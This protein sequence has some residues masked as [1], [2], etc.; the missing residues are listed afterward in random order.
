MNSRP[1]P[2][3]LVAF[4]RTFVGREEELGHLRTAFDQAALGQGAVI[5]VAGEAGIGKTALCDRLARSVLEAGGY[6]LQGSCYEEAARS[7]PYLPF[8][9]AIR[10][11]ILGTEPDSTASEFGPNA[12]HIGRIAPDLQA[13]ATTES[14]AAALTVEE[15]HWRLLEGL[16]GFF[17]ELSNAQPLLLLLEDLH[18]ADGGSVALLRHLGRS[19]SASR[20][21]VVATYRDKEVD[22]THP[23]SGVLA[24]LRRCPSFSRIR[25]VGLDA[26][27]VERMLGQIAP[28]RVARGLCEQVRVQTD[29]NPLFVEEVIRHLFEVGLARAQ[30]TGTPA[31]DPLLASLPDGLRDVIGRRLSRLSTECHRVLAVAAVIG[32][33][34]RTDVLGDVA[35]SPGESMFG[36]IEEAAA[37]GVIEEHRQGGMPGYRF[38][39]ELVRQALY[40]ETFTPRR[41]Q[42]HQEV[43]RAVEA[44]FAGRLDDHAAE[45]A[46]HFSHA[47]DPA[48]LSRAVEYAERAATRARAVFD[49][50][51]AARLLGRAL[52]VQRALDPADRARRCDLLL[53]RGAAL[54]AANEP[55]SADADLEEAFHLAREIGDSR[56]AGHAAGLGAVTRALV[57]SAVMLIE[58]RQQL[59]VRRLEQYAPPGTPARV[60][61]DTYL[62]SMPGTS[63]ERA[64]ELRVHALETA[65]ETGDQDCIRWAAAIRLGFES[66]PMP[67]IREMIRLVDATEGGHLSNLAMALAYGGARLLREGFRDEGESIHR[68]LI[69]LV[70]RAPDSAALAH[71]VRAEV[72]LL[73]LDGHLEEAVETARRRS[74]PI[75]EVNTRTAVMRPLLYL[76]RAREFVDRY[77]VDAAL[78][79]HA[80]RW[81]ANA[82]ASA[83]DHEWARRCLADPPSVWLLEGELNALEAEIAL[84]D[85]RRVAACVATISDAPRSPTTGVAWFTIPDRHLGA[86]FAFLGDAARALAANRSALEIATRMRFRPELALTRLQLAELL[87]A[88]YPLD[89]EEALSHLDA[90]ITELGMMR[91]TPALQRALQLRTCQ[92]DIRRTRRAA[93]AAALS[94]REVEVLR[95]VAAGLTNHQI[96]ESLAISQHTVVRHMSHIFR[97]ASVDNRAGATAFGMRHGLL[98]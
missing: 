12:E 5:A 76:G 78:P 18:W 55:A 80:G 83:G 2:R 10:S 89:H 51:E 56:R 63:P 43:A 38:S 71:V 98:N 82:I 39:H 81:Y 70:S 11:H 85:E 42:V 41:L 46:E 37:K 9:Q 47:S 90:A 36:A 28:P 58:P 67:E 94:A 50:R 1:A 60:M 61:V 7:L 87:L 48:S 26:A 31:P 91:M 4:P 69:D 23:L 72:N 17:K 68:R 22:R 59:W 14:A 13:K 86:G 29:G 19:L 95:L 92:D 44:R 73:C 3:R 34:F 25:L 93:G 96:A 6:V 77:L 57:N 33:E 27:D 20:L 21:L 88:R 32:R 66:L 84:G 75:G 16:S 15:D 97:K 79:A 53:A 74:G 52:K 64:T 62:A 30:E 65:I 24:D 40:E 49:H 54:L 8:A 45:L 35:G